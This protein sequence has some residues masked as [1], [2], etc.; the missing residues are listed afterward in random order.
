MKSQIS[1]LKI[2]DKILNLQ[3]I[4]KKSRLSKIDHSLESS[5]VLTEMMETLTKENEDLKSQIQTLNT[6]SLTLKQNF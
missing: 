6:D 4:E 3:K 5:K 2:T 1:N